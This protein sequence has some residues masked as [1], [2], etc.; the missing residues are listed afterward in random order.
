MKI[1]ITKKLVTE[2]AKETSTSAKMFGMVFPST[3]DREIRSGLV[4]AV[5]NMEAKGL[6]YLSASH[7]AETDTVSLEV[8]D[9]AIVLI[10]KFLTPFSYPLKQMAG[11]IAGMYQAMAPGFKIQLKE[12]EKELT[13]KL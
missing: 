9:E 8:P 3:T 2:L 11:A 5:E 12:L 13:S 6:K 4:T 10:A 1:T 7:D